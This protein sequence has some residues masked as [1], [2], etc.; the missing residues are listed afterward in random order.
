M[1]GSTPLASPFAPIEDAIEAIRYGR[2]LTHAPG[3]RPPGGNGPAGH[4]VLSSLRVC[5]GRVA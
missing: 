4:S 2:M 3:V 5:T 1:T